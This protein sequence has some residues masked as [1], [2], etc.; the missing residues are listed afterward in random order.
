MNAFNAE[1]PDK[2]SGS[3]AYYTFLETN[4]NYT[5][6]IQVLFVYHVPKSLRVPESHVPE[7]QFH[8]PVPLLVTAV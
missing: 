3:P 1:S 6:Q 8:F 7:S 2:L 5:L 4:E